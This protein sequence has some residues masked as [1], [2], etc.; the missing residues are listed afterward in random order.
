MLFQN[1][2][3]K[4]P[5]AL[6][7]GV[8]LIYLAFLPPGIFG[9]DGN[10]MVA[11]AESLVTKHNFTVPPS[12][13]NLGRDG[14]Y[15]SK[16]YPLLPILAV[17]FVA[18]GLALGHLLGLP[19]HYVAAV[20][21]SI[22]PILFTAG[23]T[24]FVALLALRLGSDRKSAYLAALSFAFGTIALVYVRGFFAE[25][26][27][28]LLIIASLYFVLGS[29]KW[30]IITA[31]VLAGLAVMAKPL[32]VVVGPILSAY[33]LFRR[34]PFAIV[35]LPLIGT[36]IFAM[37]YGIYNYAQF[38]NPL[39]FG[40]GSWFY[41]AV[42]EA[43][44]TP[45]TQSGSSSGEQSGLRLGE[46]I[47][48][49]LV[50]PGR[51]LLWYCPPVILA[52][53]GLRNAMKAKALEALMV[54]TLFWVYLLPHSGGWWPA[55]WS[56]GPRYLLPVLPGLLAF[57]GLVGKRW[58]RGLIVL[59]V[60]GFI[61]NAPTLISFYEGYYIEVNAPN[62]SS[63]HQYDYVESDP[64]GM[65]A[66]K[67]LWSPSHAPLV[68]AWSVAY[69]QIIDA[70]GSNVK[71]LIKQAGI[72]E[73]KGQLLRVVA[74]WWWILPAVGIPRWVGAVVSCLLVGTGIWVIFNARPRLR[75]RGLQRE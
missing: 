63:V 25:P 55:G 61:I 40:Q 23:T 35:R 48:G 7:I 42:S 12:L 52:V 22:L 38:G 70:L 9:P 2:D 47:L 36:G 68:H 67:L 74:V 16:W 53:I 26:L 10:G 59:T 18:V 66:Q 14:Y 33:L 17:P 3:L 69:H 24:T 5:L 28:A 31:S 29:A 44:I 58:R 41:N 6:G 20:C 64:E 15:Y 73:G 43:A 37:L 57:T 32:G 72:P 71:D 75:V 27:L 11:L 34:F 1:Q 54:V 4:M 30:E 56:W 46:G 50:S 21:A 65:F 60:I 51:G 8:G 45:A 49:L 62:L 19:G 39:S 13:G